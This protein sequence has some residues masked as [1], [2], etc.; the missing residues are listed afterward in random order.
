MNDNDT[1]GYLAAGF[2]IASEQ[3]RQASAAAADVL[4]EGRQLAQQNDELNDQIQRQTAQAQEI[5]SDYWQLFNLL[6]Q[7]MDVIA[8]RNRFFAQ[9]YEASQ[10]ELADIRVR[11]LAYKELAIQLGSQV[12]MSRANVLRKSTA[13]HVD[14]LE[15]RFAEENGTN[16]NV[17]P[18]LRR[19]GA[20]MLKQMEADKQAFIENY[21]SLVNGQFYKLLDG[22]LQSWTQVFEDTLTLA[23]QGN[24]DAQHNVGYFLHYGKGVTANADHAEGWYAKAHAAGEPRSTLKLHRLYGSRS[25]GKYNEQKAEEYLVLAE[26][27]GWVNRE[28]LGKP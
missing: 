22:D 7:P 20:G 18:V 4:A 9:T 19:R 26:K 21:N 10:Q 5:E 8:Q 11:E 24:V 12:G 23:R 13:M 2:L 3:Q 15:N 27:R 16:A 6:K 17:S 25:E 28:A 14:V 1:G